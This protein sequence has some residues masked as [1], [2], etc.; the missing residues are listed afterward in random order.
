MSLTQRETVIDDF[1][2]EIVD[3]V[4]NRF[5]TSTAFCLFDQVSA[6][7]DCIIWNLLRGIVRLKASAL[8]IIRLSFWNNE[9][10]LC[11]LDLSSLHRYFKRIRVSTHKTLNNVNFQKDRSQ[12]AGSGIITQP[13]IFV[14]N[15]V[16]YFICGRLELN[17]DL[18]LLCLQV[19]STTAQFFPQPVFNITKK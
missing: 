14:S 11:L 16:L 15:K 4:M 2:K 3:S 5:S 17:N 6:T 9:V 12:C 1:A 19:I 10:Q 18:L 8:L 13:H 7:N